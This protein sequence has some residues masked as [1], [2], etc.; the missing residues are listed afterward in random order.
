MKDLL[1]KQLIEM[2]LPE[3]YSKQK[4]NDLFAGEL[5]VKNQD[6]LESLREAAA[7]LL[8]ETVLATLSAD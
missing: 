4:I 8:Q 3:N 5:L 1:L 6:D 7:L 2:G